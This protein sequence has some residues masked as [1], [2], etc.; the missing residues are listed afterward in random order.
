[1]LHLGWGR[2]FSHGRQH[3]AL[4][5]QNDLALQETTW[6]Q[7]NSLGYTETGRHNLKST[8]LSKRKHKPHGLSKIGSVSGTNPLGFFT[9]WV[10]AN[11]ET[12]RG[13]ALD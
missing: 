6:Q 4:D 1:M 10:G 11:R 13:S 9:N 8:R 3:L 5:L 12:N 2:G 7:L